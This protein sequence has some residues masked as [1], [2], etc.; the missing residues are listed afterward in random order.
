MPPILASLRRLEHEIC[1]FE[2]SSGDIERHFF[3]NQIFPHT[4]AILV[5]G[6]KD[7]GHKEN[8]MSL[9]RISSGP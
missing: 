5:E 9:E 2:D 4:P 8:K 7:G 3:K 6:Q 1:E